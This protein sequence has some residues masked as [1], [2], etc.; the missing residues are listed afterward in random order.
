[1]IGLQ[2]RSTAAELVNK[3]V[4]IPDA[5]PW[6]ISAVEHGVRNKYIK[7]WDDRKVGTEHMATSNILSHI[8]QDWLLALK[9]FIS[10][11]NDHTGLY[12]IPDH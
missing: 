2:R 3:F 6:G 5:E 7:Q 10:W 9:Y 12:T 1:M 4:P 11:K 8:Q